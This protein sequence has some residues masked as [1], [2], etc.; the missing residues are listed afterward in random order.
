MSDVF[1]FGTLPLWAVLLTVTGTS[2]AAI[3]AG[4]WTARLVA[5][6]HDEED[7]RS[8]INLVSGSLLAMLAF[9]LAFTFNMAA[10]RFDTRKD[11]LLQ[12]V[13]AIETAYLRMDFI[14]EPHRSTA[15]AL[16][17]EYVAARVALLRGEVG[18][19]EAINTSDRIQ[20]ALWETALGLIR[21]GRDTPTTSLVVA[22][23]NEMFDLQTMRITYGV[24]YLIPGTIWITLGGITLASMFHFG[25]S[26]PP[27]SKAGVL[28][29]LALTAAFGLLI[30]LIADLDSAT[31]LI[32][33]SQQPLLDLDA[34]LSRSAPP[35]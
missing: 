18:L 30:T 1:W 34:R 7:I 16:L 35:S 20:A 17:R 19:D 33:I 15:Q 32:Q 25:L 4:A 27:S 8:T 28:S 14:S 12:E 13:N 6:S 22:S 9:T 21:S 11:L 10:S 29:V 23:L 5:R 31:G 2:L 3:A 24:Q 26:L